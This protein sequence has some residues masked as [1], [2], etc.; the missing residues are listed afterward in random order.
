M[1]L[2]DLCLL[3]VP[4]P[5]VMNDSESLGATSSRQDNNT[6][7]RTISGR[8]YLSFDITVSAESTP[9]LFRGMQGTIYTVV[10]T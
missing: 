5:T 10:T 3:K 1:A 8:H 2:G 9:D 7:Q 4:Y 6:A